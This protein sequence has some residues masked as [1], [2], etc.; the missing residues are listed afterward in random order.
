MEIAT[1]I[2]A[3]LSNP[4]ALILFMAFIW[5]Y[6]DRSGADKEDGKKDDSPPDNKF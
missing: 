3:Y 5:I 2:Y 1:T 6:F 4:I